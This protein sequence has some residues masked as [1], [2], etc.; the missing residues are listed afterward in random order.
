MRV[1]GVT[2]QYNAPEG[3]DARFYGWWGNMALAPHL[4]DT[5]AARRHGRIV[6]VY[7]PPLNVADFANRKDLAAALH[8]QVAGG[9]THHRISQSG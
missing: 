4:Y 9:L 5:L 7:H 3:K 1:Q 2:V 6:V 8:K